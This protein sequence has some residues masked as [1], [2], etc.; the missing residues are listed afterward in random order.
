MD[1]IDKIVVT[2]AFWHPPR[3]VPRPQPSAA[4]ARCFYSEPM[5]AGVDDPEPTAAPDRWE[6][7]RRIRAD[8]RRYFFYRIGVGVA[9]FLC[10]AAGAATGWLPGPGGI[11]LVLLG[12]AIWSSEFGWARR[13]MQWF[14]AQLHV[15]AQWSPWRKA[16]AIIAV[17]VVLL[18]LAYAYL[19]VLGVPG[20]FPDVA[21]RWLAVLPGV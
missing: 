2:W 16:V 13:L 8:P 18:L 9:G 19:L 1:W 21:K 12:L 5:S 10:I 7:R 4:E 14:K 20:W 17:V 15:L 6:W 11:P 3:E